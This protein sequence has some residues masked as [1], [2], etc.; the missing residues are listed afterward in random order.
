MLR[1]GVLG[2]SLPVRTEVGRKRGP[3]T[4]PPQQKT[5]VLIPEVPPRQAV[6][7]CLCDAVIKHE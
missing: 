2:A 7:G 5:P 3:A 4:G 1:G 6:R